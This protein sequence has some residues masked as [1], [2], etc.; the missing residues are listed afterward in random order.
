MADD[1]QT[2]VEPIVEIPASPFGSRNESILRSSFP[3]SP[4]YLHE[5]TDDRIKDSFQDSVLDGEVIAGLGFATTV[6]MQYY[7]NSP[8]NMIHV[9]QTTSSPGGGMGAGMT[10]TDNVWP[11]PNIVSSPGPPN[12]SGGHGVG[13]DP[14]FQASVVKVEQ[15]SVGYGSGPA[16]PSNP[17]VESERISNQQF[18]GLIP[19][20]S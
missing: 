18:N 15:T 19:G 17:S 1:P 7:K 2:I 4:I 10:V 11:A 9:V 3:N 13:A 16:E 6:Q 5:M 12:A 8:P 20:N 14:S